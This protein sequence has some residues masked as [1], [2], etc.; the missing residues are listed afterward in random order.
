M[1]SSVKTCCAWQLSEPKSLLDIEKFLSGTGNNILQIPD[2]EHPKIQQILKSSKKVLIYR[3]GSIGDTIVALPALRLVA[4]A[5]PHAERR[6]LTVFPNGSKVALMD[7]VLGPLDLVHDYFRY[8]LTTRDPKTIIQLAREIQR[9]KPEVLVYCAE[10][11]G[12]I[13]AI[14]DTLFFAACGIRRFIG[15]PWSMDLQ[16][17]RKDENV[18]LWESEA[19]RLLRCLAPLGDGLLND[20]SIWNLD[21]TAAERTKAEEILAI[22]SESQHFVCASIGTKAWTKDWGTDRWE[23]LFRGFS[24]DK[25]GVGLV[26]VGSFDEYEQSELLAQAWQGST[27]NVCG[28]LTPRE[29][30]AVMQRAV[31]FAGHDS[32]PMHLAASVGTP[33]VAIFSAQN[34]PGEWFPFGSQHRIFYHKTHCCGCR[35][36]DT[37]PHDKMCIR[38][39]SAV[40]VLTALHETWSERNM[41]R[42]FRGY[43]TSKYG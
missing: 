8:P 33:C 10:P 38:A 3:L 36:V 17:H 23:E 31:L 1:P 20:P 11:R 9:W 22:F 26:L 6:V 21:L 13:K 5:F 32:G 40:E 42:P 34:L 29:T 16:Q 2:R 25:P 37:C 19:Q 14:R 4:R 27:L 30:A 18:D 28:K 12:R 35:L 24:Q 39:I 43:C 41:L 15:V 7:S